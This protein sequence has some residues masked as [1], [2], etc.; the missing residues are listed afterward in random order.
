M[1]TEV[2][3]P[4]CQ[5]ALPARRE[6]AAGHADTCPQCGAAVAAARD[7]TPSAPAEPPWWVAPPPAAPV[8]APWWVTPPPADA[9]P[10]P[11]LPPDRQ[12]DGPTVGATVPAQPRKRR[13]L[14]IAGFAAAALIFVGTGFGLV[15]LG[16]PDDRAA[17][18]PRPEGGQHAQAPKAASLPAR[19]SP[20]AREALPRPQA[21]PEPIEPPAPVKRRPVE[22]EGPPELPRKAQPVDP[23]PAILANEQ[24]ELPEAAAPLLWRLASA[25]KAE[26]LQGAALLGRFGS[27]AKGAAATLDYTMR[28]DPDTAVANEAAAALAKIGRAGVPYLI[29]ALKHERAAVRQRAAAALALIGPEAR[30]A[31][32]ALLTALKDDSA[33]VRAVAAKALGEVGADPHKVAP[34]LCQALR[35]PAPQVN[36]QAGPA[37]ASIGE[38]AVPALRKVLQGDDVHSRRD[39]AQALAMI[40][41]AAKSAAEDLAALLQDGDRQV[42]A[43][44]AGAL[45]SLGEEAQEAIPALLEV[46]RKETRLEVQQQVVQAISR[47]GSKDM[48]GLLK[49]LREINDVGRWATPF[50]LT[51][52]GPRAKDAV[53]H[54]IKTLGDQDPGRRLSAAVA[55]GEIG[56]EAQ[57]AIPALVKALEDPSPVVRGGAAVALRKLDPRRKAAAEQRLAL[58]FEQI[59]KELQASVTQLRQRRSLLVDALQQPRGL[60]PVNRM[61]LTNPLI[62]QH[63]NSIVDAHMFFTTCTTDAIGPSMFYNPDKRLKDTSWISSFGPE[64]VPALV[65]GINLASIYRIGF[66]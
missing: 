17:Q 56:A 10:P 50:I 2:L 13:A 47:I 37:L 15:W 7:A 44:G 41:P 30:S 14:A 24:A 43:A 66:V 58:A 23:A 54:L 53:P 45:A 4:H 12:T 33:Q 62:Q 32:P 60:R 65:R 57:E 52:F 29:A 9:S 42:R 46:L 38:G 35:D 16:S 59:D 51:Q 27:A 25:K 5:A 61:A 55:L 49:A 48:P 34:A 8:E 22:T 6:G 20:A 18:P 31:A 11:L 28:D 21:E 3:C 26:R 1:Q 63:Y 40:G 19:D 64:A 39:A 36:K